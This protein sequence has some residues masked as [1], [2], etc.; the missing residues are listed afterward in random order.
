M[1]N[2]RPDWRASPRL[3]VSRRRHEAALI[4]R[5]A[6]QMNSRYEGFLDFLA[7]GE[8]EYLQAT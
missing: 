7:T 6:V 8:A 2:T 1:R 5:Q 3:F 4:Y